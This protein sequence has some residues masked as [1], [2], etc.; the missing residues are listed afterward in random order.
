MARSRA[1]TPHGGDP[2]DEIVELAA[3]LKLTAL[4]KEEI[5]RLL[6]RAE[7]EQLSYSA[8]V[9]ETLRLEAKT[10]RERRLDRNLKRSQLNCVGDRLDDFDFSIRPKLSPRLVRELLHCQWVVEARNIL[11][12]GR[13]G[14]GKTRV[15]KALGRAACEQSFAVRYAITANVLEELQAA[16]ADGS[17]RKTFQRYQ[18]IDVLILDEFAYEP[19]DVRATQHIFR[20]IS[21]RHGLAPTLLAANTGF[22]KW[23]SIFPSEAQ[24]VA[25]V[26]RLID[27]ATILHF[28]GQSA[29]KPK[30][31]SL[32]VADDLAG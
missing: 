25:T 29:R 31:G 14:L 26:D 27:N 19:F 17:Y 23:T 16:L 10:R 7:A 20:L 12:V 18:R 1:T 15:L 8:F 11:C 28:T 9:L 30:D 6:Q 2:A 32:D 5:A 21:A 13:P 4:S 22:S 3:Q 24:A